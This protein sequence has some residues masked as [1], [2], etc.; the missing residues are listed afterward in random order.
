[1]SGRGD[2]RLPAGSPRANVPGPG[3]AGRGAA[4]GLG[5]EAGAGPE[6]WVRR[7]GDGVVAGQREPGPPARLVAPPLG[8]VPW[9]ERRPTLPAGGSAAARRLDDLLLR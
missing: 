3:P 1:M 6:R 2:R 4:E 8:S 7:W 5:R 9:P